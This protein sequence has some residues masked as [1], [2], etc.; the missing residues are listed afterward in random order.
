MGLRKIL[1][2]VCLFGAFQM[3]I[4]QSITTENALSLINKNKEKS[5]LSGLDL[6]QF[7]VTDA[8]RSSVSQLDLVYLQQ[9]H[10]GVPVFNQIMSLAFKNGALVSLTGNRQPEI[11]EKTRN[12]RVFPSIHPEQAVR[13]ALD[14]KKLNQP[15]IFIPTTII[16]GRKLDFGKAGIASVNI[17][18]ELMWVVCEDQSIKLA[19]QIYLVPISSSDYWLIRID[20]HNGSPIGENNLTV[21]CDWDKTG[22][23]KQRD[24]GVSLRNM[25]AN[26]EEKVLSPFLVTS[27]ESSPSII[28]G[29]SYR[30]IPFPAESPRHPGGTPT[31]V[32][33]PWTSAPGNA[34]SLKWHNNGTSDFIYT[35]GN[36]VWAQEDSDGNNGTGI[37][38]NS[39]TG[40]DPLLFDFVPDFTASPSITTPS[41]NRQ[42]NVTN[43]FYWNNVIHDV[44][45]QYGFDEPAGNFQTSNQGR[46]GIGNDPVLADAQDGSGTNNANFSTPA[47]GGSGRMQMYLWNAVPTLTV[48]TPS[49]IAGQYQ[50]VESNF[51][52]ANKLATVGPRTGQVV[53][54]NDQAAGTTHEGCIG[55]PT[56]SVLGKIALIDRGNCNFTVKVKNAQTAGAIA[57]IMVNN[58]QGAP[59]TM[60]GTDNTITIPAIMIS[61]N[62]GL[63]FKNQLGNN[64]NVTIGVGPNLDGDVDNG[65]VVHE[66][67]HG[68]SNRLTGGPSQ[69]SCLGNAE[70]MG[71]GWSDYYALMLTQ[72]WASSNLNTGALSPRGIGTYVI[73]QTPVQPGIRTQKYCT[74]MDINNKVYA[75]T[76]PAETHD[77]GEIWCAAL[78]DMT[79]NIIQQTGSITPSIYNA[80]SNAGNAI[81][82]KLVTEGMKLQ[83]CSPGFIDG[84]NAILKADS[85]LFNGAYSCSIKEAFRRRGM[86]EY[87]SQGSSSSLTDQVADYTPFVTVRKKTNKINA[88]VGEQIEFTTEVTSCSPVTNYIIR[89]TL[90][91]NVTYISGGNYDATNRVVSFTVN[92]DAGA[93]QLY[94]Y[95]VEVNA[96]A[97]FTP[98]TLFEEN[99]TGNTIPS[100]LSASSTT[101]STWSV[102]NAQSISSPNSFFTPNA[103]VT[104]DQK[105]ESSISYPLGTGTSALQFFHRYQAQD[106]FDGAVLEI[107]TDNGTSWKD[108]Q[109]LITTGYYNRNLVTTAGHPLSG[110]N[111]WSGDAEQFVFSSVNLSSFSNQSVKFRF[112]FGSNA[113]LA[114]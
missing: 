63:T 99:V 62:D 77:L 105:L 60:G 1:M 57:V 26:Q 28:N 18:A 25:N 49:S 88:I 29:A 58:V 5:C 65:V 111:A 91:T 7:L 21:Y 59:I 39:S 109:N 113:S 47:D 100:T 40:S 11:E 103:T 95:V 108:A 98:Q 45:Y 106:G 76:I 4:S 51:S 110:R 23:P 71:E 54:Y 8:Y 67:S 52:T 97:Y 2:M 64:L 55:Q 72:D 6:S 56:N 17:T 79:W 96:G 34:T 86:G 36:N 32:T 3:A 92:F 22:K 14:A 114:S 112:R 73:G 69:A 16:P 48:N 74:D 44:M 82:L 68:T 38:T 101:S 94:T 30:V 87:A 27:T 90:P 9:T 37:A 42:F 93:N 12:I 46:G 61:I 13:M 24:F 15:G 19:W 35:R 83:P 50:A 75:S 66:F 41:P 84:R 10:N 81:A 31:L 78:W 107:S 53:Y 80:S 89:D 85:I 104:S 33:N 43:L 20:A 102:S 70:Q